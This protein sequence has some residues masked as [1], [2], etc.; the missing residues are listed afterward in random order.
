MKLLPENKTIEISKDEARASEVLAELGYSSEEAVV[1]L[2][3]KPVPEDH[4]IRRGDHVVVVRVLSGGSARCGKCGAIAVTYS[5]YARMYLCERH[6]VELVEGKVRRALKRYRMA[7]EGDRVL[8]AIS[9][10]KDSSAVLWALSRLSRE[11]GFSLIGFHIDLG[12]GEYS[13]KSLDASRL[14]A[15]KAGVPLV[16]VSVREVTGMTVPELASKSRRPV[17][18]VCGL[19]KRYLIN[20]AA[21]E[22]GATVVALGHNADDMVAYN[23]KSFMSQDLEA[24]SKL[25]PKTPSIGDLAVGRIRPLYEVYEKE[26]YLY[27]LLN[28][29]PF[30]HEECP[31][32]DQDSLEHNIKKY[33]NMLEEKKPGTKIT[34]LRTLAKR[35]KEYPT[36]QAPL[37]KCKHC[38]LIASGDECSFCR[39]TRKLL[40]EPLGPKAREIIRSRMQQ[41][42]VEARQAIGQP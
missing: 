30:I 19:V 26:A 8:V 2:N 39:L 15:R 23:L 37:G 13:K 32:L 25:G 33:V 24:I 12:I 14:L 1:L 17:C 6:L 38:G 9:G 34:M 36:P 40:G 5:R 31:M 41:T 20:A 22:A 10:G 27:S 29:L 11:L 28:G 42:L 3:G 16:I 21:L 7:G 35:I 18:S 4:K